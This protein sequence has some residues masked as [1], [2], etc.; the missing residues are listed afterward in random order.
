MGNAEGWQERKL[1]E[2]ERMRKEAKEDRMA[3]V[4]MKKKRYGIS[5]LDKD[6]TRGLRKRTE[7]RILIAKARDNLWKRHQHQDQCYDDLD[8]LE[9][10][11]GD[12]VEGL[13]E[14]M[15]DHDTKKRTI[16]FNIRE[17]VLKLGTETMD[18]VDT[19]KQETRGVQEHKTGSA[20][21]DIDEEDALE[22]QEETDEVTHTSTGQADTEIDVRVDT[23]K[24]EAM[25]VQGE[26]APHWGLSG[27]W[28]MTG[29][30]FAILSRRGTLCSGWLRRINIFR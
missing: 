25:G 11:A 8:D 7:E 26:R 5:K 18:E 3:V 10:T 23:A 21:L 20:D 15:S 1:R 4:R 9:K 12:N 17:P 6:E 28:R 27:G 19:D 29:S 30:A 14:E 13:L 2:C 24:G 22:V 16:G